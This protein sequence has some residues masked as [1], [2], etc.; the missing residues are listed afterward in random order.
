MGQLPKESEVQ[1][2]S[3]AYFPTTWQAVIWRNWGY[4]PVCR[5]AQVLRTE[6]ETVRREAKRMGLPYEPTVNPMWEKRGY[7]TTIRENWHLCTYEQIEEL[8]DLTEEELAFILKEDDFMWVKLGEFKPQV[9]AA[10]YEPLTEEQIK[11]TEDIAMEMQRQGLDGGADNAFDFVLE[12]QKPASYP[13]KPQNADHLRMVYPY[14]ALYGDAL[15]DES[16]DPL[17]EKILE[18]YAKAGINGIWMQMVLYQLV[19]FP[20]APELSKGHEKRIASLNRLVA[21]AKKYGIGIY[22]YLNEPRAMSEAFFEQYPDLK[23]E[24]EGAYYAMC[25][26][27]KE[28]Q[29]YLYQGVRT[30]FEQVPDLAGFFTI[31]MSENLTNC[32]SRAFLPEN[33]GDGN[34]SCPR[35]KDRN[36]WEVVAEVNNLMAKGAHDANPD[37]KVICWTWGW[38]DAWAKKVVPLL[39]QGQILQCTSE[40]AME[41]S[42]GGIKGRVLDYTLSLCGPGEKAKNMWETARACGFEMSAKVQVNN[43]WEMAAVPFLPVFDKV[44][45]H[46]RQLQEVGITHLHA[47]WTLGGCPSPNLR[48]AAWLMEGKGDLKEFLTDWLGEELAEPVYEAQKELS[49]AFSH[50]PFHMNTLYFGPQN[51]GPMAPFFLRETGYEATMIGYPY[52]NLEKWASIYPVNVYE[53]E[54][55]LLCEGWTKGFAKLQKLQGK[56]AELDEVILM[57]AAADCQFRSTYHH[58]QFVGRRDEAREQGLELPRQELLYLIQGERKVVETLMALRMEDSRIGYESSNQYFYTMQDLREK[59]INLAWCE[60][61]L[62][63]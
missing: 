11:A 21:K 48:L 47:G 12:Y 54:Y 38:P 44:E 43:T 58:I 30:L 17:P 55:G 28:V 33:G 5:I 2:V 42:I 29:D 32:Y 23:G 19:E 20:F 39:N 13:V 26:S 62:R 15:I 63:N 36:P 57:A 31:T 50:Y 52:D 40:E 60:K 45:T 41:Y 9:K 25:T 61:N 56:H 37:A 16:I 53:K 18:E 6:E 46:L 51:F 24:R 14:F 34:L 1:A 10:R 8:L 35:C 7:L 27:T 4:L 3:Y 49:E 59:M 22:P